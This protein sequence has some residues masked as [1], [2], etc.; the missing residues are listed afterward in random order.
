MHDDWRPWHRR[1]VRAKSV[2]F[3]VRRAWPGTRWRQPPATQAAIMGVYSLASAAA[4]KNQ[5]SAMADRRRKITA[6]PWGGITRRHRDEPAY[7]APPCVSL[8]LS[9][10]GELVGFPRGARNW[11]R[12]PDGRGHQGGPEWIANQTALIS[13]R[14]SG[15]GQTPK[16]PHVSNM[17]IGRGRGGAWLPGPS[18][19]GKKPRCVAV[20]RSLSCS[21]RL[22]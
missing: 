19:T 14:K 1:P 12:A 3:V 8:S 17:I 5:R 10:R 7:L 21:H 2:V 11:W 16:L 15:T 13:V 9:G 18:C 20:V 6:S 22:A 4:S